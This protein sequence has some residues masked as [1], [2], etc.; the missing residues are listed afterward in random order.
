[1]SD[2]L[3]PNCGHADIVPGRC[4]NC[5]ELLET[6]AVDDQGRVKKERVHERDELERDHFD[7]TIEDFDAFEEDEE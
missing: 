1:M 5:G 6:L 4:P 7:D 2:Y 3:C